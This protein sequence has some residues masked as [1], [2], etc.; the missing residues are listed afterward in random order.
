MQGIRN[1]HILLAIKID[2]SLIKQVFQII[3][4]IIGH[5]AKVDDKVQG[6]LYLMGDACAQ[7]AQRCQFIGLL[8]LTLQ[9]LDTC[10]QFLFVTHRG[11]IYSWIAE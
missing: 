6:V 5:L 4:H 9:L 11:V 1:L 7:N 8:E 3:H 10:L 2:T